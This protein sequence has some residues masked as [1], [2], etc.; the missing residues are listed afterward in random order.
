MLSHPLGFGMVHHGL[1]RLNTEVGSRLRPLGGPFIANCYPTV[2][3]LTSCSSTR[4]ERYTR[5]IT[6]WQMVCWERR[7]RT[8]TEKKR[9]RTCNL[10]V[11]Y[12][13]SIFCIPLCCVQRA[14]VELPE[15]PGVTITVITWFY[16]RCIIQCFS[17]KKLKSSRHMHAQK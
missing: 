4:T 1:A 12:G 14:Q 15:P 11:N 16:M 6:T 8:I 9:K 2:A 13:I 17:S 7:V 5:N 10:C 3:N